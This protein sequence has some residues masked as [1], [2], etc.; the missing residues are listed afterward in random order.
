[1]PFKSSLAVLLRDTQHTA[2]AWMNA[3]TKKQSDLFP[4]SEKTYKHELV[5]FTGEK[6]LFHQYDSAASVPTIE[7]LCAYDLTGRL[8]WEVP[9]TQLLAVGAT[10]V[11]VRFSAYGREE[12]Q[13][14]SSD[15]GEIT[16]AFTAISPT[17][18]KLPELYRQ[19]S[20]YFESFELFLKKFGV[21]P[22]LGVEYLETD[23]GIVLSFY[24]A[25]KNRFQNQLWHISDQQEIIEKVTLSESS[26]GLGK[27]TFWQQAGQIW[28][29]E[30][31]KT[32]RCF[33]I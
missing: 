12:D 10:S 14:L 17:K 9:F 4:L 32:V 3:A 33:S 8:S 26:K 20:T 22:R 27:H 25:R 2:L 15:T 21:K 13:L 19:G 1:M 6:I 31:R 24:E 11:K 23:S 28:L 5:A 30:E 18:V 29:I 16:A 7:G